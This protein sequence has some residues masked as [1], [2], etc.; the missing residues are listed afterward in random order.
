MITMT[1]SFNIEGALSQL[2]SG[3]V[4]NRVSFKQIAGIESFGEPAADFHEQITRFAFYPQRGEVSP[5]HFCYVN[6]YD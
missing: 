5:K 4:E 1:F 2:R 3:L 6:L